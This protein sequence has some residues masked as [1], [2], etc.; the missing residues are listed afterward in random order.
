MGTRPPGEGEE[1]RQAHHPFVI[2]PSVASLNDFLI[3]A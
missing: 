2:S 1:K 3:P